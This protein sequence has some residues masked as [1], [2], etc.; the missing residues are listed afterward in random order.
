MKENR[1]EHGLNACCRAV[2]LAKSSYYWRTRP[3]GL[4]DEKDRF[5]K[6]IVD[7]ITEHPGYGWRRIKPEL[8]E[9]VG[10]T[11]NHKRLKRLLRQY[12]LGLA[13]CLPRY[14]RSRVQEILDQHRGSLN[15]VKGRTFEP[16]QAFT[17]DFTEL[18]YA[19]GR[20]KAYLMAIVDIVS[21][22]VV[23]WALGPSA[24][25]ELALTCW[26]R[27]KAMMSE[28]FG[29]EPAGLIVHHDKDTVYTSYA[30]LTELLLDDRAQVSFSERGAKDNPWIESLW[31]RLKTEISSLTIEAQTIEELGKVLQAHFPYYNGRRRHSAL[32][33]QPPLLS[34]RQSMR[35]STH[36]PP[37]R[38]P[39]LGSMGAAEADSIAT[40]DASAGGRTMEVRDGP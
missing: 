18:K 13:R 39:S 24:N 15:L 7:I 16:L 40:L 20:R 27:S 38:E 35:G 17:T 3:Q 14:K 37:P 4:L 31:G 5:H 23:G 29:V 30:W 10:Y 19:G 34:L 36:T 32:G 28:E 9:R 2:N 8:E 1:N 21:R 12:A 11:V 26:K 25:R 33:N 22:V 6:H